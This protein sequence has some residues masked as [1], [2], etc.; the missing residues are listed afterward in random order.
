M[1]RTCGIC[2]KGPLA[3][4]RI[5][6]RGKPKKQAG[7]GLH[8]VKRARRRQLPNLQTARAVIDGRRRKLRVCAKCLKTGRLNRK[9]L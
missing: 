6:H 3:G 5:T 9:R 8:I 2:G 1:S 4:H 7:A